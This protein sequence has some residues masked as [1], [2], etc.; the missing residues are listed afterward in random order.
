MNYKELAPIDKAPF[1]FP[2]DAKGAYPFEPLPEGVLNPNPAFQDYY[3]KALAAAQKIDPEATISNDS[4]IAAITAIGKVIELTNVLQHDYVTSA[5]TVEQQLTLA[6]IIAAVIPAPAPA[7]KPDPGPAIG[8]P[9]EEPVGSDNWYKLNPFFMKTS[10]RRP[11]AAGSLPKVD[12]VVAIRGY[13]ASELGKQPPKSDETVAFA[14]GILG[15]MG[16]L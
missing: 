14:E 15:F 5:Q 10:C 6:G 3:I 4:G 13:I 16:K 1:P 11:P 9:W 12:P 8:V 7:P 2:K